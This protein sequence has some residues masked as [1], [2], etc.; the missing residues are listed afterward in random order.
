MYGGDGEATEYSTNPK[1]AD[2]DVR[3]KAPGR[4]WVVV[5]LQPL[6]KS[7]ED[8]RHLIIIVEGFILL[9]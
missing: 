6:F 8:A 5:R 9:G 1:P 4:H 3:L 7:T 2:A